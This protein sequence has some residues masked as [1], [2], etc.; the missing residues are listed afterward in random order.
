MSLAV[1]STWLNAANPN[2]ANKIDILAG[3]FEFLFSELVHANQSTTIINAYGTSAKQYCLERLVSAFEVVS[4][5]IA[6]A[7][8]LAIRYAYIYLEHGLNA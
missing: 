6:K 1:S 5:I 7:G 4:K 3:I 8:A 2:N